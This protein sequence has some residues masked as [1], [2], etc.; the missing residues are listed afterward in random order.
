MKN[1]DKLIL[2][3]KDIDHLGLGV[4][5]VDNFPVFV[6]NAIPG[7]IVRCSITKV[8]KNL[9]TASNL[10]IIEKSLNRQLEVC[11][12]YEECG[13]CNLMHLKYDYQLQYKTNMVKN[14]LRKFKI[15][16][17]VF[18]CVKNDHIYGYRNKVQVPLKMVD[19]KIVS[20]FYKEKSHDM[21]ISDNCLIEDDS[22]RE[23]INFTKDFFEQTNIS[24]YEELTHKGNLRH[25]M[26][27]LN[28][29]KQLMV[30]IVGTSYN[31]VFN[32]YA[33]KLLEKYKNVVSVYFN[34][35]D[36][37]T[38]VV[39]GQDY[40]LLLGNTHLVEKI[41]DFSFNVHPNSFMQVNHSSC[42]KL[43]NK[44]IMLADIKKSDVVI[45][46]YCGMGSITLNL[47]KYAKY[48]YGIEVVQ[49]AINDA[50][51]NKENNKVDNVSFIC[52]KCEDEISKLVNSNKI[53]IIFVDP[54]RKGCEPSF[55]NAVI[56]SKIKKIVY[57][58]CKTST[59]ARD[60]KI[61]IDAGYKLNSVTPF[62][63]FSHQ[64]H[65]ELCSLFTLDN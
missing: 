58:S 7:E 62:D 36:K 30:V 39:L 54:P 9:A 44:A 43:Y 24:V 25:I 48:V 29:L 41:N 42:V 49:S 53:D 26:I 20:G 22:V 34:K 14:T 47:S 51:I 40:K 65:T 31:K 6:N 37:Q 3:I 55:L 63:L 12:Y 1:N 21:V 32:S 52:G 10:E 5:H 23:V 4:G 57:I 19:G 61:L 2:D 64:T 35:N 18:D 28:Y 17:T 38:N 16:T 27:R 11:P 15:E 13:G 59:F 60:A 33:S 50:L 8:T 46:A 56:N 45:D